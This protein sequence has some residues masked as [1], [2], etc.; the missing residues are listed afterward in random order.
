MNTREIVEYRLR[1]QRI[2]GTPLPTPTD[3]V[4]WLGAMQAQDYG[5]AKWSIGLR[6][7][8]GGS[9]AA[10][11]QAL[12]D[13][14]ILR[15][16]ILRPTWHFVLP[17]D[18]RWMQQL[19]APR[20]HARMAYY[21]R[22]LGLDEALFAK[23]DTLLATALAD[24]HHLTRNAISAF[25]R[26]HGIVVHGEW[27]G[28]VLMRAELNL[29]ICSGGLNGKR[30]TYA[31]VDDRVPS[32]PSLGRDEALAELTKRYFD[33]HGPAT[34]RDF[35][36]WSG[37][38]LADARRGLDL[39]GSQLESATVADRTY[40]FAPTDPI[41][42]DASPTAHLLPGY[43]E[44]VIA[45]RESRDLLD[46]AGVFAAAP[47]VEALRTHA[48]IVDGQVVGRWR[49]TV[50]AKAVTIEAQLARS[51]APT[52]LNAVNAAVQRYARFLDLPTSLQLDR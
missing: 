24:G 17:S 30:Q 35:A 13:G 20:V 10:L 45:Y 19:T 31:L 16:H 44:F 8:G 18:I 36:W 37:L 23:T 11:D 41:P 15:T 9:D 1:N 4:R 46:L 40:W 27:L 14:T 52:E 50:R 39:V 26:Q 7:S 29:L 3:V 25:L 12:G 32:A 33:S 28:H 5:V 22:R 34:A 42:A 51:L 2:S 48:V 49:R 43:D 38:T 6:T 47:A 21:R